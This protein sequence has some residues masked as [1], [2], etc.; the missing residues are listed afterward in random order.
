MSTPTGKLPPGT[1]QQMDVY[2]LRRERLRLLLKEISQADLAQKSGVSASYINRCLKEPG[3]PHAKTIGEVTARKLESGGRKPE[4]WLDTRGHGHHA[5]VH[6]FD[7]APTLRPFSNVPVV[8]SVTGGADG[9]LTEME[10]PGSGEGV[11]TY[12]AKD[13]DAYAVR[14]RGDSMRPRIK[15]GEFIVCEPNTECQPGDDV[16]VVL[17]DGRRMVKELLY[18]RDGEATL[19]SVNNGH[20]NVTVPLQ[21][22]KTMHYVAAIIPRGAFYKP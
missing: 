15:A 14:V 19:G 12:P 1:I 6:E 7:P 4:G 8:G 20:A 16:V 13:A 3:E 17:A 10:H 22:I 9:Y 21:D 11:I 18:I 2:E 5:S